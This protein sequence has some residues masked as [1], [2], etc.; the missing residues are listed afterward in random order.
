MRKCRAAG[1]RIRPPWW[2]LKRQMR[3]E[4]GEKV[5]TVYADI[6]YYPLALAIVLLVVEVFVGDAPKRVFVRRT[7]PAATKAQIR[8]RRA[9]GRARNKETKHAAS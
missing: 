4:L 5:E 1:P 3:S 2:Q 9:L 6:Y 7:P 8:V